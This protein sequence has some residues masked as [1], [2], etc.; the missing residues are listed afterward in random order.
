ME[1]FNEYFGY[2]I[3]HCRDNALE[4]LRS[5]NNYIELKKSYDDLRVKLEAVISPEA[6]TVFEKFLENAVSVKAM[7]CNRTLLCGLTLS[8]EIHKRFDIATPEHKAF[9]DEYL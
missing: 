2:L 6:R 1:T 3:T 4:E 8:A 7:E 9:S 5:N